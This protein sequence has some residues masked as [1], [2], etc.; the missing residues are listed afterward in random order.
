MLKGITLVA[1]CCMVG[2]MSCRSTKDHPSGNDLGA[3]WSLITNFAPDGFSSELVLSNH[4]QASLP[5]GGWAIYF[6]FARVIIK[7]SVKG[8]VRI[9]HVNGDFYRLRPGDD[10]SPLEPG[11]WI[12]VRFD[13][14]ASVINDSVA[15]AGFY[16]V[17]DGDAAPQEIGSEEIGAF[18]GPDQTSRAK[19]DV[20][21]VQ[22]PDVLFQANAPLSLMPETEIRGI[23]PTPVSLRPGTGQLDLTSD[24]L[25]L[26][27]PGLAF[28]ASYLAEAISDLLGASPD[29]VEESSPETGP[30][31]ICL[32]LEP[33][34]QPS[35]DAYRL[36][37]SAENGVSISGA[38]PAGVLC[39]IQTLRAW[40]PISAWA[41]EG[42]SI[43]VGEVE[44]LDSPRFAYRGLHLDVARNFRK[45]DEVKRLLDLMA[46]YKLNRFHFHIT[47][48]EGWRLEIPGLPE[49]TNVGG[50]R[51]HTLDERDRLYPSFGSGP[52]PD[53]SASSGS[54]FYSRTEFIDILRYAASR[55]IEVIP[56]I[57]VPGHARAAIK[58]M[59]V[60]HDR[61]MAEG[62]DS[63]ADRYLLNDPEDQSVYRSVQGW[64][65]NV[66]NVC[67]DSTYAFLEKVIDEVRGMY[68]EAGVPLHSV[69]V[70]GDE[71]PAGVWEGSPR[72]QAFEEQTGSSGPGPLTTYFL[73]RL[74]DIL[75]SRG[76]TLAGWEEVGLTSSG[77]DDSASRK[78]NPKFVNRNFVAY[79]WNS[80]W[81]SGGE[82]N[83]YELANAG[84]RV[85]LSNASNLYFD[86]A[87][88]KHPQEPGYYWAGFVE[89][90]SAWELIPFDI[91]RGAERDV[92]GNPIEPSRYRDATRLSSNGRSNILGLQG[93]L[94]S[95]NQKTDEITEYLALPKLMG[96]SER[97]WAQP[98][99]WA[100]TPNL[101]R[102]LEMREQAWNR[103][104]NLVGRRELPRLDYWHGGVAYRLPPPGA[105][106]TDG[107]LTANVAFPG[108]TIRYTLDG[109]AP[110]PESPAYED[111]IPVSGE[112]ILATFDQQGR[113]SRVSRVKP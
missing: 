21:P 17:Y 6:N 65:D 104:A 46:F 98:P 13:G 12:T 14:E 36:S 9:E 15:P 86:L 90:R 72:C 108:L 76:L 45:A 109:K 100:E 82:Q 29:I 28:E 4:G 106:I 39:G 42:G 47:D 74:D 10:F 87:Y 73:G 11:E 102:A 24:F 103:F 19:N 7:D 56:E 93:Q 18:E 83:A 55:H 40:F 33:E 85:V 22:T 88:G 30:N 84:Y 31:R 71:V 92:M 59:Q 77:H 1:C 113:R 43:E 61:L 50:H 49:L 60:R 34:G 107:L 57:D 96:L 52:N 89:T 23:V 62:S 75:S 5:T 20:V 26:Y 16:I 94:W 37:I 99:Q 3:R 70:G 32:E 79:V 64:N 78:P 66:V 8:P 91:Y 25:L 110:T 67:Q 80:V 48:D 68:L 105:S 51:G 53:P 41:R 54:G 81:G 44:V 58:S 63:E 101:K 111:P 35:P 97:A 112:V 2:L 95:E 27:Q 38:S 69:H